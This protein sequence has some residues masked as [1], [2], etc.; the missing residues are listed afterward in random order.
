VGELLP[1]A[2]EAIG[3]R[4]KLAT[5]ALDMEH[6]VGG[7][8]AQGFARIL[9][10]TIDSIDY[11]ESEIHAGIRDTPISSVRNNCPYGLSCVVEFPLRGVGGY[12]GRVVKVRTI[13]QFAATGTRPRLISALLKP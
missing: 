10:I 8:K 7:P 5:Y 6:E 13:W 9:G 11:L 3:V 4:Y 1:R 12:E 2:E